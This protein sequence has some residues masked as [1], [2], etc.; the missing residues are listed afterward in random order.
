MLSACCVC[1]AYPGLYPPVTVR[2]AI[3]VIEFQNQW[4]LSTNKGAM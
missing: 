1:N 3:S 4:C 2:A